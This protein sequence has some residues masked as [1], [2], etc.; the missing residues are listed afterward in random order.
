[1]AADGDMRDLTG[2]GAQFHIRTLTQYGPTLTLSAQF[3][4]GIHKGG[5]MKIGHDESIL[6]SRT[7][8]ARKQLPID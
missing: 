3:S 4:A 7:L 2:P 6:L 8:F 5:G 1:M